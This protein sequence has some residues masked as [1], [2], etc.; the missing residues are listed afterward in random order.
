MFTFTVDNVKQFGFKFHLEVLR[1]L[2]DL[3]LYD[4][5][6]QTE[7]ALMLKAFA[8]NASGIRGTESNSWSDDCIVH[9][10]RYSGACRSCLVHDDRQLVGDTLEKWQPVELLT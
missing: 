8:D 4:S 1:S 6:F 2:A 3:Q 9:A 7:G 10:G 5:E